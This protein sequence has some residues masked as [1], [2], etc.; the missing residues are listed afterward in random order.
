MDLTS[1]KGTDENITLSTKAV[2][3]MFKRDLPSSLKRN[4]EESTLSSGS[5]VERGKY[6]LYMFKN[7]HK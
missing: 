7:A 4:V 2:T 3:D 6:I 1:F 5:T